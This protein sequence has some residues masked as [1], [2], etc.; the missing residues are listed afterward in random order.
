MAEKYAKIK[1]SSPQ[2]IFIV[3]FETVRRSRRDLPLYP[4]EVIVRDGKGRITLSCVI[5]DKGVTN[6]QFEAR[7]KSLGYVDDA[8]S[9]QGVRRIR[10]PPEKSLP[11]NAKTPKEII[12][13]T[14]GRSEP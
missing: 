12:H 2:K 5:H 11:S 8:K 4:I 6:A 10:G 7:L 13:T 3:D 9:L 14:R 1:E